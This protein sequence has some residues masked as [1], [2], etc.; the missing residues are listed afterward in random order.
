MDSPANAPT[1][2]FRHLALQ[3]ASEDAL[4]VRRFQVREGIS[5]LFEIDLAA[6]SRNPAVDFEA[7]VG[8][9]ASFTLRA[10]TP[11]A[12]HRRRSW[13]GLCSELRQV[14]NEE[15]GLSTYHLRLV[16]A[17]WLATQRSNYR[18]FQQISEPDIALRILQEW[19][20]EPEIGID[21]AAY[22]TRKY[23][24][25]YAESDYAFLCRM[26]EDAGICFYFR[27]TD[28]GTRMVLSDAPQA[29]PPRA[30]K[31]AFQDDPNPGLDMEFVTRVEIGRRVRPGRYTM[32]DHDYRLSPSYKLAATAASAS[33]VED[34]LERYHYTPGAFLFG[35]D[36]GEPTPS[37]DDKGRARTDEGEA[38]ALARKRLEA[39]RA[40][41][42]TMSFESNAY[43]LAPG[44]VM[45]MADHPR[46]EL[47]DDKRLLVVAATF[48][49]AVNEQW[50]LRCE[51]RSADAPYRPALST[52]KPKVLGVESATVVGPPGE[53]I[54][55][56]EFGRVR[57][58]FHWDRGSAM[59]DNSSC[60]IHVS[61]PWA[62]T[63]YGGVNLPRIGQEVLVSFLGGDPDRPIIVGRVFTNLQKAPFSLPANKTQSGWKSNSTQMTGGY[64]E[65][66]FEDAAGQELLR[67][68]AER[69]MQQLVKNNQSV[70]VGQN[71]TKVI[72]ANEAVQVGDNLSIQV[73]TNMGLYVGQNR[74]TRVGN[75]DMTTVANQ[76]I[77]TVTNP[78]QKIRVPGDPPAPS[79]TLMM[80]ERQMVLTTREATVLLDGPNIQLDAQ[81][82]IRIRATGNVYIN[83]AKIYLN[84]TQPAP[85]PEIQVIPGAD[86]VKLPD[87]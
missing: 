76:Y 14:R 81:G 24:V 84:C 64:N 42:R 55:T 33:G 87:T 57:V 51:A 15:R 74:E 78:P 80:T 53:E 19:G 1:S 79:T 12:P 5:S 9:P 73:G 45:S 23:R 69:D 7:V 56:D 18:I 16:P 25:Q 6:V 58:H 38:A 46:P 22:K 39:K 17:L 66:M 82:E 70:T 29:N 31:L 8:Q 47:G 4:D 60:W 50:T 62:G 3:V 77:V 20:I 13:T 21:R 52:R 48:E 34:R 37:A 71:R 10:D 11:D 32:R 49:G 54:H 75:I 26:L 43:D 30:A 61:Q 72:G 40:S 28:D 86:P 65:I 36:K 59:D 83:G 27:Q 41:V 68:Q 67:M 85:P 35:T 2:P 44:V 63:G